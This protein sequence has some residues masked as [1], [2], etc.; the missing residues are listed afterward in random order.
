M[1]LS[2]L[3]LLYVFKI[4]R[5]IRVNEND[6]L[7][8]EKILSETLKLVEKEGIDFKMNCLAKN[9]TIS[10]KTIYKIFS[11]K[12]KLI[13]SLVE[14]IFRDIKKEEDKIYKDPNLT[15][16]EKIERIII[17][18]PEKYRELNYREFDNLKTSYPRIHD[19]IA[20]RISQDWDKTIELLEEGIKEN[21]IRDIPIEVLKL[22]IEGSIEKLMGKGVE[23]YSYGETLE[24]M[25]N[26]LTVGIKNNKDNLF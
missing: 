10:K 4:R 14:E 15:V 16:L 23:N 20:K 17:A 9:L 25:M 21:T 7:I 2:F 8:K 11:S 18:M 13:E 22:M 19:L 3:C 1:V 24:I 6:L 12:E 26:I 5:W